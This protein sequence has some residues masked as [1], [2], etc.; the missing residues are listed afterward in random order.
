MDVK[1]LV[2]RFA[3]LVERQQKER[4]SREC[5]TLDTTHYYAVTV[6]EGAKYFRVD[7]GTSG[8]FMVDMEGNI[9]GIKA[10]GVINRKKQYGTLE[11]IDQYTWGDYSP[12]KKVTNG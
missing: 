11:T 12:R 7:V 2:T 4:L 6:K 8:K 1:N 5:P 10:Y 9:F 3:E